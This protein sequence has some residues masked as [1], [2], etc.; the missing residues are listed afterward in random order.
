MYFLQ[1]QQKNIADDSAYGDSQSWGS[2]SGD[3]GSGSGDDGDDETTAEY[4]TSLAATSPTDTIVSTSELPGTTETDTIPSTSDATATTSEVATDTLATTADPTDQTADSTTAVLTT[5]AVATTEDALESTTGTS[6]DTSAVTATPEPSADTTPDQ[7]NGT[8]MSTTTPGV[9]TPTTATTAEGSTMT[10][11]QP[12]TTTPAAECFDWTDCEQPR[13]SNCIAD[14]WCNDG[15]CEYSP[16]PDGAWCDTGAAYLLGTCSAGECA[17]RDRCQAV[18]CAAPDSPCKQPGYCMPE[19]GRCR[20]PNM[21]DGQVCHDRVQG[22]SGVCISGACIEMDL[23]LGVV[24]QPTACGYPGVCDPTNGVCVSA[25][26]PEGTP[27]ND[28]N[29]AT[30]FDTCRQGACVGIDLCD[31][32]SC[33]LDLQCYSA[34]TC[35]RGQCS[36]AKLPVDSVCDDG[37]D[38]TVD[39]QC[40]ATGVC[41]G[42]D[43]CRGVQCDSLNQCM[44]SSCQQGQCFEAP[45]PDGT[46]CDDRYGPFTINDACQAGQ[47]RGEF[48]RPEILQG[49]Q[50]RR[51]RYGDGFVLRARAAGRF[52]SYV[53]R[54]NGA[55]IASATDDFLVWDAPVTGDMQVELQV[56]NPSGSVTS[57]TTISADPPSETDNPPRNRVYVT[58]PVDLVGV[59]STEA[60][61]Q[62]YKTCFATLLTARPEGS[63]FVFIRAQV[64]DDRVVAKFRV[65]AFPSLATSVGQALLD[66]VQTALAGEL[67]TCLQ[68]RRQR[69]DVVVE[70]SAPNVT[71]FQDP[72]AGMVCNASDSCHDAGVCVQGECTDPVKAD[73][74]TC[75]DNNALTTDD[76]CQRGQC[77]GTY[78]PINCTVSEWSEFSA[79]Q[80]VAPYNRTRTRTVTQE[81]RFGGAACPAL[82]EVDYCLPVA[83]QLSDYGNYTACDPEYPYLKN[84]TRTVLQPAMYGGLPCPTELTERA[85]CDPID[86]AVSAW[87]ATSACSKSCGAG[88]RAETR[89]IT[90]LPAYGGLACPTLQRNASCNTFGCRKK[91]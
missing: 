11:A 16:R 27:C 41:V 14:I 18:T 19:F 77:I 39:D 36:Y 31:F 25:P 54:I 48:Q 86:C 82:Q 2:G 23:C 60:F 52:L 22:I 1:Q 56:S 35:A 34:G 62:D 71:T 40:T 69:R 65:T 79:C 68:Q 37:R 30:L 63:S 3:D 15:V 51:L 46:A 33:D 88:V 43:P 7:T 17:H 84:R 58:M 89:T 38:F 87:E 85:A 81:P 21:P 53:W 44:V 59:L 55:L 80:L 12:T 90:Q 78:V 42:V 9:L 5:D 61:D 83:C 75:D 6:T 4:T 50:P 24:C 72:C 47:C 73:N 45:R 91:K 64:S 32:V 20:Y 66:Y 28:G 70:G 26:L 74:T 13:S 67:T 49:L 57:T 8:A 29:A 76:Q 10:T